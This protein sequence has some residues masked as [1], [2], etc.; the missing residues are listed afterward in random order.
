MIRSEI[1]IFVRVGGYF[2]IGV[3]GGYALKLAVDIVDALILR[4]R[5]A[6]IVFLRSV[7]LYRSRSHEAV[8]FCVRHLRL[9]AVER[10]GVGFHVFIRVAVGLHD[11]VADFNERSAAVGL[12]LHIVGDRDGVFRLDETAV[13][14]RLRLGGS[15]LGR[16]FSRRLGRVA[17]SVLVR[18]SRKRQQ[19]RR[20]QNGCK[21]SLEF[22]GIPPLKVFLVYIIAHFL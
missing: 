21:N 6:G 3:N 15:L 14:I 13:L 8:Y 12:D 4:M 9:E 11:A 18:A 2:R 10:V 22:H 1:Q 17:L 16:L 19:H 20:R 7:E 5:F